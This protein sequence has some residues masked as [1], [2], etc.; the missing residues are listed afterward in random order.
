MQQRYYEPLA[1]RFLSVDPITTDAKTGE[2]FN[3][4]VYGE[5][6]PF[7]YKDPDGRAPIAVPMLLG[8]I[9]GAI[10]A[11]RDPNASV[12][13]IALGAVGGAVAGAV[14][15]LA[16]VG[17]TLAATVGQATLAGGM[18]NAVGQMIG[19]SSKPP[20][21]SQVATQAVISGI[22]GVA[23][24]ATAAAV[25]G[26]STTAQT[27]SAASTVSTAVST[28]ANVAVPQNQGGMAANKAPSPTTPTKPNE[29][30]GD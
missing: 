8:A 6:N 5:N 16:I 10:G 14:G 30:K 26:A 4:Y 18:G 22:G 13:K 12:G 2:H 28:A 17:K 20:D 19:D 15:T 11:M 21:A 3:R 27:A 1:G 7:R 9:S 25:K 29:K 24:H 23:G